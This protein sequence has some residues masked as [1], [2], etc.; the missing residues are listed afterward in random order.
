MVPT[1]PSGT[2]DNPFSHEDRMYLRHC[3]DDVQA[4]LTNDVEYPLKRALKVVIPSEVTDFKAQLNGLISRIYAYTPFSPS[5]DD[6][7]ILRRA[8]LHRRRSYVAQNEALQLKTSHAD[9]LQQLQDRLAPLERMMNEDWFKSGKPCQLPRLTDFLSIQEVYLQRKEALA[10]LPPEYDEKFGILLSP[11]QFLPRLA[12]ARLEAELRGT[13]ISVG[14]IDIDDF[15]S[16]NTAYGEFIVDKNVLPVFMRCIEAHV[17]SQGYAFRFGGDEYMLILPNFPHEYAVTNCAAFQRKLPSL[18]FQGIS[19]SLSV[20]I[21]LCT[22]GPDSPLTDRELQQRA[23]DAKQAAKKAGKNCIAWID[24]DLLGK[25]QA[26][27]S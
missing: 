2:L 14:F 16:F 3:I 18:I 5:E 4:W 7:S 8:I 21:G 19:K 22:S 24:G 1:D 25:T 23:T 15:K 26:I 12:L 17:H 10:P 11:S 6:L 9:I 20:S 27:L 13:S